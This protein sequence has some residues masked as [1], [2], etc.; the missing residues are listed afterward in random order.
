M[1]F[2]KSISQKSRFTFGTRFVV[3]FCILVFALALGWAGTRQDESGN[4]IEQD[5]I[6]P[7]GGGQMADSGDNAIVAS[8][9]QVCVGVS[10]ADNNSELFHGVYFPEEA[11]AGNLS[12]IV[13]Y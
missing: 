7:A 10:R 2:G 6:A 4:T 11:P 9:G 1:S 12:G 13:V 3:V 8:A 5:L